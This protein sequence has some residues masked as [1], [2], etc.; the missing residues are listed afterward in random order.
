MATVPVLTDDHCRGGR[1][2]AHRELGPT[3]D[4][5]SAEG[6]ARARWLQYTD[7]Y[8]RGEFLTI[9]VQD[10]TLDEDAL[11]DAQKYESLVAGISL[12]CGI[13]TIAAADREAFASASAPFAGLD[14]PAATHSD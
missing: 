6:I 8:S 3:K 1:Q 5:D 12:F 9:T 14:R 10:V 4:D 11:A 2:T 7:Y 13:Q